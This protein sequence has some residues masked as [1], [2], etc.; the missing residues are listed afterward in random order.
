MSDILADADVPAAR[1]GIRRGPVL[2]ALLALLALWLGAMAAVLAAA[3]GEDASAGELL[4]LLPS[5]GGEVGAIAGGG[6]GRGRGDAVDHR[7][8]L[9]AVY[10]EGAGFAGRLRAAGRAG[11]GRPTCSTGSAWAAARG[12]RPGG[13]D[14]GRSRQAPRR[15]DVGVG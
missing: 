13:G 2:A 5:G 3:E 9:Y 15:A 7:A 6:R 1:A 11:S 4:A 10:G 8:G 12:P 14:A